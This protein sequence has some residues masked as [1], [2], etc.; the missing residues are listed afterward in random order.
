ML[1]VLQRHVRTVYGYA[2]N[3]FAGH[4]PAT[5]RMLQERMGLAVVDP[6]SLDDQ[7]RLF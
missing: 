2:N 5:V 4:A 3:H 6:E 7:Q 1:P